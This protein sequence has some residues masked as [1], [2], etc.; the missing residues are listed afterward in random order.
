MF[1][2][3]E[4]HAGVRPLVTIV[5]R[6]RT[7]VD[8]NVYIL[9]S[10][11]LLAALRR[12]ARRGV[13]VRVILD[14]RPYGLSR[15]WV[16]REARRVQATGARLHWAPARFERGPGHTAFDHAKYL[17]TA[18]V[19]ELGTANF[20]W[21]AF[22]RN[23][24]YLV[25]TARPPIVAALHRVFDA[26]WHD[27]RAGL[28]AHRAL[29]LSPGTSASALLRV[30]GQPDAVDVESEEL[31]GDRAILA[32]VARRGRRVRLLLPATLSAYDQRQAKALARDGV[33]VRLLP[34]HP[35]YLHAK[36]IVGQR[37]GFVGSEN[38]TETSL[39]RN[40]EV[41]ILLRGPI[42]VRLRAVFE[43]D[44]RR[45]RALTTCR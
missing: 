25:V 5:R 24:E 26:D 37:L 18:H 44:W 30:L 28:T 35:L 8:L 22:H 42:L 10:R 1:L 4:P 29:V 12:A 7:T 34:R 38:F 15:R 43:R 31:G 45:G 36:M 13:R 27:R 14:R 6:A 16:A 40:R 19:C 21:S 39:E 9:S 20:D 2:A 33:C 11:P 17:C 23:R 32:A 3:V 41:G